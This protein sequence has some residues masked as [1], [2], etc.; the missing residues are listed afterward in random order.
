MFD[1][2]LFDQIAPGFVDLNDEGSVIN[3]R[4]PF[5]EQ[6]VRDT[7]TSGRLAPAGAG[8]IHLAWTHRDRILAP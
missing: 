4:V 6:G 8:C 5:T 7:L 2:D 1:T 3:T